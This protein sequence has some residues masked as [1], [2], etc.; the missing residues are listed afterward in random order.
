MMAMKSTA[1]MAKRVAGE[2][3]AHDEGGKSDGNGAKL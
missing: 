2:D 3:E 1:A